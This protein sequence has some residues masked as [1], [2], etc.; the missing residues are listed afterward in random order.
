MYELDR[1]EDEIHGE[2]LF[3]GLERDRERQLFIDSQQ[4][5]AALNEP[6]PSRVFERES[7]RLGAERREYLNSIGRAN[8]AAAAG[9]A[10]D[11]KKLKTLRKSYEH[12]LKK[13][14]TDAER[15]RASRTVRARP[16]PPPGGGS[17]DD[18]A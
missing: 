4:R 9:A 3:D 18:P 13:L 6:K 14:K 16:R 12:D 10:D 11:S 8:D 2:R 7:D 15:R 1:L 5:K 17:A